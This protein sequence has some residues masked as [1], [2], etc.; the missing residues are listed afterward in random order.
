MGKYVMAMGTGEHASRGHGKAVVITS[1][2]KGE[3]IV[4]DDEP[5][6]VLFPDRFKP[7]KEEVPAA[8][9]ARAKKKEE[10]P[11]KEEKA[12]EE[13]DPAAVKSKLGENVTD[14]FPGAAAVKLC[15]FKT[16]D[17]TY[18]ITDSALPE[19][20]LNEKP[21]R[22]PARVEKFISTHDDSSAQE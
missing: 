14:A 9:A 4:E 12:V 16:E 17:G 5:L 21:F 13:I 2:R 18:Q 11:A 22:T 8:P 1:S 3:Q 6:D 10:K 19:V 15:V 7:Y 20:P